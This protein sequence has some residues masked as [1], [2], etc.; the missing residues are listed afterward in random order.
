MTFYFQTRTYVT[1]YYSALVILTM[2]LLM[3]VFFSI[4]ALDVSIFLDMI[5]I[6]A[7][8]KKLIIL[9]IVILSISQIGGYL[10]TQKL[11]K[12]LDV[13]HDCIEY[14]LFNGNH[15]KILYSE[16]ENFSCNSNK[17]KNF[18]FILRSGAKVLIYPTIK[19]CRKAYE[20][21]NAKINQEKDNV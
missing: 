7:T 12:K 5:K 15:N 11:V 21:I 2:M 17:N 8:N 6:F 13:N 18:E 1:R 14:V 16:I 10:D 19:N 3:L 20:E 4:Y 9:L